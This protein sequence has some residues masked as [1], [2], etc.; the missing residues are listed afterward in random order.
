MSVNI[1]QLV[2]QMTLEEKASLCS[3]KDFWTTKPVERLGIP[4]I[5]V[6]DG[7]HG[8]RKQDTSGDHLGLNASVP[9][10][11]FPT[12][13]GLANSWNRELVR[14]IG[15]SIAVECQA[16]QVAVVLGPGANIK[17]SPLCGRNFEYFSED[18]Y[19]SGELAASHID[20][21]QSEGVGTSLKHFAVNNQETRRMSVNA[22]VDERALMEIYLAS[23]EIPVRKS[24]PWTV[25]CS[26][27][28]ING[29][30]A[31]QNEWLLTKVLRDMWGF[32]GF[33]VTDWGAMDRRVDSLAA[34]TELEM[35]ASGGVTDKEIVEA[36]KNGTLSE[37]VLDRAV[38][39]FLNI[40]YRWE[41]TKRPG[42]V[43]DKEAH[44]AFARKAAGETMVLAKN[45]GNVLPFK[46]GDFLVIGGF[47][48]DLPHQGGGSSHINSTKVDNLFE[49]LESLTGRKAG[50]EPGYRIDGREDGQLLSSAVEAAKRADNVIIVLGQPQR[51][52]SE[53]QDRPHM[54]LDENQNRLVEAVLDVKPDAV[55]I[56]TCG[57]SVE[58]PWASRAKAILLAYLGGQAAA[59]AIADIL[60]GAVN[61]SAKLA[62]TWPER[63]EHNPSHLNFPGDDE[64]VYHESIYVGYRY[65]DKKAI[66]PLFPF[67]H[68]LSYTKFEYSDIV[69]DKTVIDED[70]TVTVSVDV[71]N[72]G[73]VD[74]A[75]I[76]Q[77]YVADAEG[78]IDRP[79]RELK[80]FEKV[81]LKSGEKKTVSFTLDRR[82]FAY[83]DAEEHDWLVESGKFDIEVGPSSV[84]L[85]LKITIEVKAKKSKIKP[86]TRY[87][88]LGDIMAIPGGAEF[89]MQMIEQMA[90][91]LGMGAPEGPAGED[92]QDGEGPAEQQGASDEALG[93][94]DMMELMKGIPLKTLASFAG[95]KFDNKMLDGLVQQLN[96]SLLGK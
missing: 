64:V 87:S 69:V 29:E 84:C 67:G 42:T 16:E 60:T 18:P 74:G 12:A 55:V 4:S 33:V 48:E 57:S 81:F 82:S 85:P 22:V 83:W 7:P 28:R 89:V 49:E 30:Y 70:D 96:H 54:K 93:G 71:K 21:V 13:A 15:K 76:V 50:Y 19:L 91:T 27:N 34:G 14:N 66:K 95:G 38:T 5:F 68:G 65:Y 75:E 92:K 79:I 10:T 77:L 17:R 47:A 62:E 52:I 1:K 94:M 26:Y 8:L 86:I 40:L 59:G 44:H 35:P 72:T 3:G 43:F 88:T 2:S 11:C 36:V 25:M 51:F 23:F 6:S 45:E 31:C 39:R 78:K 46:E 53:G 37:E 9:A 58:L 24:R 61:P 41:E 80:G 63:L 73:A 90:K 20:G 32:E 56:V